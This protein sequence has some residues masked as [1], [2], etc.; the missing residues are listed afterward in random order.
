MKKPLLLYG[1][2][3]SGK[4]YEAILR[5]KNVESVTISSKQLFGNEQY[6]I[7]KSVRLIVIEEATFKDLAKIAGVARKKLLEVRRP[8][9]IP[10][11]MHTPDFIVTTNDICTC[12]QLEE[13]SKLYRAVRCSHTLEVIKTKKVSP[14]APTSTDDDLPF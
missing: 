10:F 9:R 14:T 2:N 11:Y 6:M 7:N 4:S 13:A 1:P 3:G 5:T 12:K 8:G